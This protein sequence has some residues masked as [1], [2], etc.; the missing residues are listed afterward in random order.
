MK[1]LKKNLAFVNMKQKKIV[2]II[3]LP[4]SFRVEFSSHKMLQMCFCK[5]QT[6]VPGQQQD[7]K[8]KLN[9]YVNVLSDNTGKRKARLSAVTSKS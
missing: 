5:T 8:V 9:P 3:P 7:R 1:L 6:H 4:V 2:T